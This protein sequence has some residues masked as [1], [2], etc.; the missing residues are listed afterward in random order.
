MKFGINFRSQS[1]SRHCGFEMKQIQAT[2]REFIFY[3]MGAGIIA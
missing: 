3:D 2:Y 1:R